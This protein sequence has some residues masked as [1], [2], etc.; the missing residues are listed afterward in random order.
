MNAHNAA[1]WYQTGQGQLSSNRT[2]EAIGSLRKAVLNDRQNSRYLLALARALAVGGLGEEARVALLRLRET[3][4]EDPEI[5][6]ELARLAAKEGDR[7]SA[8]RY[9][10]H[11]LYGIWQGPQGEE[12]RRTVRVELIHFFISRRERERALSELHALNTEMPETPDA[13]AEIGRLFLETGDAATALKSFTQAIRL[14]PHNAIARA[15]AGEAWF[16]MQDY[17]RAVPHL[18]TALP[19]FTGRERDRLHSLLET[20]QTIVTNDPLGPGL[21]S[22]ERTRRVQSGFDQVVQRLEGCGL[23]ALRTEA[24]TLRPQLSTQ[25]LAV[26]EFISRAE[27][28]AARSCGEPSGLDRAWLLIAR[29]RVGAEP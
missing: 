4:P 24:E 6:L 27:Q 1:V 18:E 22:A 8:V 12:K 26:L 9:Y 20:A 25:R 29:K 2:E 17:A 19:A 23:P 15:G 5:N 10:H 7:S 28:A 11:A 21:S 14:D 16:Q 3:T 13:Q